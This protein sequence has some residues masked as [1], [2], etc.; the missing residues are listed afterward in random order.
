MA[1]HH[2]LSIL[3]G[4]SSCKAKY[5]VPLTDDTSKS[6]CLKCLLHTRRWLP[7]TVSATPVIGATFSSQTASRI[8]SSGKR[9]QGGVLSPILFGIYIDVLVQLVKKANIGCKIGACCA[10]IFLYADDI[11]LL[12]PTHRLFSLYS[13]D[14]PKFGKRRS[15]AEEFGRMFGS[16][17]LGNM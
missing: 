14:G 12:A 1:L 11:I 8:G 3:C 10:G 13:R 7:V 2:Y 6:V 17:R 16:V 15:S 5:Y 9:R 4:P